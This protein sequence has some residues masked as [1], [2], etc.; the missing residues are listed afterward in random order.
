MK[1]K[2]QYGAFILLQIA[3]FVLSFGAVCSKYAGR[4]QFLSFPFF[5]YYGLL[6]L[7]LFVY[8]II[9]QQV[10]KKLPLSVA[11]ASKGIGIVYAILWGVIFFKEVITWKMI[12]GAILVLAG[13]YMFIFDELKGKEDKHD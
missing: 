6:L 8:A 3:L 1:F 10:L 12:V 5:V 11:Y 13:V 9:W 7:I 4:Q 2:P